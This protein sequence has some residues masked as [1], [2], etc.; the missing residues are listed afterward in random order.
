L[1]KLKLAVIGGGAISEILHL[2][3]SADC[4]YID[5][6]YLVDTSLPRAQQLA[7]KYG[8]TFVVDDYRKVI[9]EVDAAIVALPNYLHAPVTIDL[10][11]NNIHV[12]IEKPMALCV[13]DCDQMIETADK[14]TAVL[15]VGLPY[16][17]A[18]YARLIKQMIESEFFGD[19]IKIELRQGGIFS[20]PIASDSLFR[21]HTAGGGVLM[22]MGPHVL[23]LLLWWL[24]DY[25]SL[26]YYDDG[27]GGVEA[28]CEVH[29]QL[30]CG[31]SAFV[32][33]SR[34]RNMRNTWII[35]GERGILE[36]GFNFD[37]LI[38]LKAVNSDMV[39]VGRARCGNEGIEARR[40]AARELYRRQFD[41]FLD[42]IR[43]HRE[44]LVPGHQAKHNILLIEECYRARQPL[45]EPWMFPKAEK[46]ACL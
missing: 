39:L 4:K 18:D 23:D 43:S 7:D 14:S 29:L 2:P 1:Q 46:E 3:V 24:G 42:A 19:R 35:Q 30:Q 9:G 28:N 40:N 33:L 13:N 22:D 5:L 31:A 37:P 32:E 17:F 36:V 20:W 25:S 15:A 38:R 12:L 21:R 10:L 8:I 45:R 26:E 27:F 16:R 44:P 6:A 34:T 41:D 11:R